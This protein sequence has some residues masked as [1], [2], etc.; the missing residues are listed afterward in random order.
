VGRKH[1]SPRGSLQYHRT[2]RECRISAPTGPDTGAK[3]CFTC[4]LYHLQGRWGPPGAGLAH[5]GGSGAVSEQPLQFGV[6]AAVGGVDVDVRPEFS[7]A[8]GRGWG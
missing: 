8:A 1:H 3:E 2:H 4:L 6:L 5:V 7:R